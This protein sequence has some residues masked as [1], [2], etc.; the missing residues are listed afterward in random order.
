MPLRMSRTAGSFEAENLDGLA[1]AP[2]VPHGVDQARK[3]GILNLHQ[4][5][6]GIL[7]EDAVRCRIFEWVIFC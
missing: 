7:R 6:R 4:E 5:P 3:D 2:R 1:G